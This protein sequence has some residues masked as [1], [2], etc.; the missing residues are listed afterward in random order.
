MSDSDK[1]DKPDD[2]GTSFEDLLKN[3]RIQFAYGMPPGMQQAA[4]DDEDEEDESEE[5]QQVL[6][7]IRDFHLKPREVKDYLDRFVIKQDD[8]KK[9]LSVA[10]CDH[11]NHVR[12]CVE[13]PTVA[14]E[15]YTKQNVILL[16]PTGVGKTYLMR[17][18]SKLIGVPF[19]KADA[20]KFSET[21]YVGYDVDDIVRDLVK[22]ADGNTDLAQYGIVY[23]DEIDKIAGRSGNGGLRDVSGR[24]VQINLLKLME[25]TEVNLQS[26]TDLIGQM[27]A[28][29][30]MQRG[31]S[32]KRSISTKHI[33]FIVSGA[34]DG[35]APIV[36]KRVQQSSIGFTE[37]AGAGPKDDHEVLRAVATPDFIAYGY[38]PEFIG[39]LPIRVL[40][41]P[42]NADDLRNILL[43]SEGS[44]LRQY[45]SDFEGYGI[46]FTLDDDAIDEVAA[47]AEKEKTGARGL[48]TVLEGILREFKYELPSTTVKELKVDA[49]TLGD[50]PGRIQTLMNESMDAQ[51]DLLRGE[52]AAYTERFREEH[53]LTL[54]L[55][56]DAVDLLVEKSLAVHKTI[57]ALCE[58]HF[59]NFEYGL[60]LI[61][62]NIGQTEFTIDRATAENPDQVV[63]EWVQKSF[64]ERQ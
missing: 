30:D 2:G 11:Y 4:G 13:D 3:A 41:E 33:L 20:T 9:V 6:E 38:E 42:L 47:R 28:M 8:A 18:I 48:M 32:R 56:D 34:F 59:R 31:K 17:C 64:S 54:V 37:A 35:M 5:Q 29:M 61:N 43:N 1:K 50:P 7:R 16:G 62:R 57:R 44:I 22:V 15:E 36:R 55:D 52:V 39:R 21:G 58:E 40:C 45:K 46:N 63:S 60:K 23:V 26:Q 53:G 10:I 25:D 14:E 51:K 49:G 12:R 19:V 27:Q 24:G